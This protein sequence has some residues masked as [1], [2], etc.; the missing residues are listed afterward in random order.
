[1]NDFIETTEIF[2]RNVNQ[3]LIERD[4]CIDSFEI[5]LDKMMDYQCSIKGRDAEFGRL[6]SLLEVLIYSMK[7]RQDVDEDTLN[8]FEMQRFKSVKEKIQEK[9]INKNGEFQK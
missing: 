5:L 2:V 9:A 1:M 4:Q 8:V 3:S 7:F 6:L